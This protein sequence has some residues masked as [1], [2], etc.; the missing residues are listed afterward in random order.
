MKLPKLIFKYMIWVLLSGIV[1]IPILMIFPEY[2][3]DTTAVFI[4]A[5]VM[6]WLAEKSK[7]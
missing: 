5:G 1:F 6:M 7:A 4:L 2:E 3:L